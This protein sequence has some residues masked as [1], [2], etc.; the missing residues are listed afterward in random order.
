MLRFQTLAF[1]VAVLPALAAAQAKPQKGVEELKAFY[2]ENCVRCHG[3]DGSAVGPDGKRLKGMDFTDAG[4]MA[5]EKDAGLAKSILKGR[6]FGLE[7]PA[8][9]DQLSPE[10][11]QAMVA[12]VLRKA[13]KGKAIG[14][15]AK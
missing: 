13:Q 5:R 14:P 1:L 6:K 12:E 7:M 10:E 4:A 2:A 15:A 8:F 3:A 11:A 9:K